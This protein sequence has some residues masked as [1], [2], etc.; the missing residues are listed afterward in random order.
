MRYPPWVIGGELVREGRRRAGVTQREL[1]ERAGTTQSAIARLESG[2]TRPAL[3]DVQRLLRLCGWDLRVALV[4]EDD[5]DRS[6]MRPSPVAEER[7]DRLVSTR[8]RLAGLREDARRG[9]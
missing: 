8:R 4:P 5:S 1:A 7:L 3:E 9:T 6:Q 2:R